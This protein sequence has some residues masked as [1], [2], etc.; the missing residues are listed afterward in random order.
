ML[1]YGDWV[2]YKSF[3][4]IFTILLFTNLILSCLWCKERLSGLLL[5][6]ETPSLKVQKFTKRRRTMIRYTRYIFNRRVLFNV[7]IISSKKYGMR[8]TFL[9]EELCLMFILYYYVITGSLFCPE[10]KQSV[11]FHYLK[12]SFNTATSLIRADFWGP[13][14]TGLYMNPCCHV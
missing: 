3:L 1:Y 10:Q 14:T 8:D 13:L 11:I 2:L 6:V 9:T 7:Y 4:F 5:T 12:Y